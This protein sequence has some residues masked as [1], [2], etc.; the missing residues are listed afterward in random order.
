[1]NFPIRPGAPGL[2]DRRSE[3][4]VLDR[5][6]AGVQA[7]E[8]RALVVR[9]EPGVGKTVLLEYLAGGATRSGCEVR[10][11]TGVQSE[12]ELAFAGLHQ[13]CAPMLGHAEALPAPQLEALRTAFGLAVGPAPDRF[14]VG[15]AVL[16]LLSEAAGER[17]LVCVVDDEQWLDRASAQALGF[18]AWR[19]SADPVGVVFAARVPGDD[20]TG[21]PQLEV[22]GL[23]D[24]DARALLESVLPGPL[25]ARVREQI[26]ADTH[27]NPLALLELPREL[28]PV[29]LA[30]GFGLSG[31]LPGAGPLDA[32]IE[33]SFGRQLE[34]LP[35]QTRRLIQLA[36]ADPSGD[37]A[38]VWR[39]AGRLGIGA[40]AAG[41]AVEA[42]LAEFGR[43]VRFRHP[44]VRSAAY[45]SASK[46][47]RQEIHAALAEAT[48]PGADPDQRAWHRAQAAPGPDEDV[49]V[50][51]E[52]SAGRAQARGGLA[53]AA[54]FLER[55]ALLT[56]EPRRRAQ[57]LVAAARTLRDA[58]ALDEALG[59]LVMVEAG[60]LDALGG[61]EVE[62][63]RGQISSDQRRDI[64][65]ARLLLRAARRFEPVDV[66]LARETYLEALWEAVMWIG[67]QDPGGSRR[68]ATQAAR[69][70]PPCP[71]PPGPV[72]V[73]LDAMTQRF[74][75]GYAAAAPGLSRAL[76]LFLAL[77]TG[78]GETRR[79]FWITGGRAGA[80]IAMELWDFESWQTLSVRQVLLARDTGALVQLRFAINL[81]APMHILR[82]ELSAA[83]RLIEEDRLI[84]EV[85]GPPPV[86][87]AA[88]ML[89]AWRGQE[90]EAAGL[91]QATA[92]EAA[93]GGLGMMVNFTDIMSAML[94][95]GLGQHEAARD[96]AWRA[97]ERD[98]FCF[99]SLVVPELAEA[100][101]R[102][103][104]TTMVRAALEWMTERTRVTPTEWALGIE[105]MIRALLAE[106]D[107][108][109]RYYRESIERLGRTPVR[110]QLARSRLL[111]GQWLHRKNR[112]LDARAELRTAYDMLSG[113]GADA[114]A[115]RA[116]RELLALGETVRRR[117]A[118]TVS[119]LTPQ[120]AHIARLAVDG[121]T[122]SEIG[123]Q[124]FLSARTVEWHLRKVYVKL[125]AGSRRELRSALA[126][127]E[128][129]DPRP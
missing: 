62:R 32:R 90:R 5:F 117:T 68:E 16:G 108:A 96:A 22:G 12:M 51:L 97:F 6:V 87:P 114:F 11:A 29:Q 30:G 94:H 53:A 89:W 10:R 36:A 8:G 112:R 57:R 123:A 86:T 78:S 27:G 126:S 65:A 39:A 115:E 110:A 106:G 118:E 71:G 66:G 98:H 56:P 24:H 100:A 77:D 105:A 37:A 38:L 17:P 109:E 45:R 50:E 85:T 116:R 13:L 26:I 34:A 101:A 122:N 82:G 99:G 70:A 80:I 95:N 76:E 9:G 83:A 52:R 121:S 107:T 120:E 21:L 4:V 49:A 48:D 127:L 15:L 23:Q 33:G 92:Q 63:L 128:P 69:A 35:D 91:I 44:L 81:L 61:A 64:D 104:D 55:A 20:L 125:G 3:C 124:L 42:G 54:A 119:A 47:A 72:D 1:M 129:V 58:G 25:D 67:D 102:T 113:M 79:W 2:T 103:G 28:T 73:L 31:A 43:R 93:E 18:A 74:T 84:A 19:L 60:S 40:Q 14:L 111:Y 75:A 59:L 88:M 41:P 46:P 7:G